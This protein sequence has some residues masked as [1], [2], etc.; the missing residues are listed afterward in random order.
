M[1][2]A[3]KALVLES[4]AR[5]AFRDVATPAR[6]GAGWALVR[7]QAA[8][9]CGSD[10]H[11]AFEGGAYH[12]PLIM[13]HEMAGTIEEPAAAGT[14]ARDGLARGAQVVVFPLLPCRS[15]GPCQTGD[16]AQCT[17]YDYFG[18]RRDGGFAEYLWA[19]E[20][21]LFPVRQG[22]EPL[23]AAMTEPCAV[24]LHGVRRMAVRPGAS[25]AVFGGGPVG[26]MA[27]QWLR[28]AGSR[29]VYVV[30]V[31]PAKLELAARMGFEPVDGRQGDAAEAIVERTG[32]GAECVVEAVGLPL[33]YAQSLKAASRGGQVVLLGN[34][35]GE[36]RLADKEVSAILRKEL[37]IYGTW[38]SKVAPRGA[39]DWSTVL[40]LLDREIVVAPLITHTP[41]LSEG[42]SVL[43]RMAARAEPF[44]K[45]VFLV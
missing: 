16:Y 6:P 26:N 17:D 21:N 35:A 15:C 23:H 19:P 43:Q 9:V 34:L 7:I 41:A 5:L 18:S 45:V 13:G 32:G 33:T 29:P 27:A 38:N 28:V 40:A 37:R 22:L 20:W 4:N 8:G 2:A 42:A 3:M 24:A 14:P 30:D 39:D 25:G 10:L 1:L 31:E 44:G 36:L 12:P 11:R